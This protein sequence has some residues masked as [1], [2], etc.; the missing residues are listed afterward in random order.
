MSPFGNHLTCPFRIMF[1]ISMPWIVR[2]A[3]QKE[4]KPWLARTRRLMARWSCSMD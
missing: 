4:R 3:D 1:I 2:V